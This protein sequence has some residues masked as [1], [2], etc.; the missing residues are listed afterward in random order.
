MYSCLNEVRIQSIQEEFCHPWLELGQIY[1]VLSSF[2]PKW[3]VGDS[4]YGKEQRNYTGLCSVVWCPAASPCHQT[5]ISYLHRGGDFPSKA[6]ILRIPTGDL[7]QTDA[8]HGDRRAD[9]KCCPGKAPV[10]ESSWLLRFMGL[11]SDS[12]PSSLDLP[13]W[14][15]ESSGFYLSVL[16]AS[17]THNLHVLLPSK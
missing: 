9:W 11:C 10:L 14:Y 5:G 12:L 8:K 4:R 6:C 15:L 1:S 2:P 16:A 3:K 17:A 7:A 13:D